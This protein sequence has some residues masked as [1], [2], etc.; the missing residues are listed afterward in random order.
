MAQKPV[1]SKD[2]TDAICALLKKLHPKMDAEAVVE[3]LLRGYT[4]ARSLPEM[5]VS[6][7]AR[8]L[9]KHTAEL[10]HLIPGITRSTLRNNYPPHPTL[11]TLS[12]AALFLRGLYIG[13]GYEYCYL[14]LLRKSGRLIQELMIQ[15]GTVDSLPF[16]TRNIVE[17]VLVHEADAVVLSH[18]HPGGTIAPSDAD[19]SSTLALIDALAPLEVPLIDHVIIAGNQA[20]SLREAEWIEPALWLEQPNHCPTLMKKWLNPPSRR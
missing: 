2:L 18:N 20:T 6:Q 9:P 16:Y 5:P 15:S 14:L 3:E 17:A 8:H 12:E 1:T 19:L 13:R 7:L 11:S 4:S 10:L